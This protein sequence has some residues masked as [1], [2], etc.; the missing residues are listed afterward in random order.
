[1]FAILDSMI[2]Q[3][4]LHPPSGKTAPAGAYTAIP[5]KVTE[6]LPNGQHRA[7]GVEDVADFV[8]DYVS[9]ATLP[10]R[11]HSNAPIRSNLTSLVTSRLFTCVSRI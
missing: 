8:V 11:L 1:M 7:A 3:P 4:D 10:L 2:S 5:H 9:Q 6:I